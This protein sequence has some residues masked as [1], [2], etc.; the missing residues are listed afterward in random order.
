VPDVWYGSK[1]VSGWLELKYVARLPHR[2]T[3][4]VTLEITVAQVAHLRESRSAG[5]LGA[6]LLGIGREWFLVE[7]PREAG[8]QFTHEQLR[9]LP[10]GVLDEG[11]ALRLALGRR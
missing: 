8:Q 9:S 10:H 2:L 1:E 5:Y 11:E 7:A 6:C 4:P 3:T